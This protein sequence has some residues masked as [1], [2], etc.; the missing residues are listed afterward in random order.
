MLQSIIGNTD[1]RQ[2]RSGATY[3]KPRQRV[4]TTRCRCYENL[5]NLI[6]A[7]FYYLGW[8]ALLLSLYCSIFQ[9]TTKSVIKN[10]APLVNTTLQQP[11]IPKVPQDTYYTLTT[12]ILLAFVITCSFVA[13][14]NRSRRPAEPVV[15]IEPRVVENSNNERH[16]TTTTSEE[17]LPQFVHWSRSTS[18]YE[19]H[20]TFRLLFRKRHHCR[21]CGNS[22]CKRHSNRKL[23]LVSFGYYEKPVRVC[24]ACYR[25]LE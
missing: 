10:P 20:K 7:T 25:R 17:P 1:S 24:D 14:R 13:F 21:A 22:F 2:T 9:K 19:C 18:C 11:Q 8:F 6:Q 16:E 15:V 23:F 5:E 4:A 12:I 3:E